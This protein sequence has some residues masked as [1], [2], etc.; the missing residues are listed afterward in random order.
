MKKEQNLD[1]STEQPLTIPVVECSV[2]S[3]DGSYIKFECSA[4]GGENLSKSNF[5]IV[6]EWLNKEKE[7]Y[8]DVF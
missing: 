8:P 4:F 6:I 5:D 3:K 7:K 1:N 2:L